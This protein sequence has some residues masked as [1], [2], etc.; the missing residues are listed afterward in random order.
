[1]AMFG[2]AI[3]LTAEQQIHRDSMGTITHRRPSNLAHSVRFYRIQS[4]C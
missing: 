1:M 2:M 3:T 4:F